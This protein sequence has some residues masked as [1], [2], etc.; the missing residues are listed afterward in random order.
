[1]SGQKCFSIVA[2]LGALFVGASAAR[3]GVSASW[4]SLSVNQA[5]GSATFTLDFGHTP[6][7]FTTD[8]A[9]R[10]A[11]SF[12]IEISAANS[13][14]SSASSLTT[15]V[16][17]DEIHYANALVIRD[18]TPPLLTDPHAGGWGA[19]RGTVPYT[20]TGPDLTFTAPLTLLGAPN[21]QFSYRAFTLA[22]GVIQNETEAQ[23]V[24]LPS[25]A[26]AGLVTLAMGFSIFAIIGA[27]H[28]RATPAWLPR[29]PRLV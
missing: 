27:L 18:A 25:A 13:S 1:M 22:H 2:V 4:E 29:R 16:R 20:I 17:G 14:I 12:Q 15:I 21:G 24:P 6:D 28:R 7:F 23:S 9:G 5:A 11:D 26:W 8:S 10:P 3:G 19:I